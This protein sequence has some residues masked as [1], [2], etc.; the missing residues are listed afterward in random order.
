MFSTSP[1]Q[2]WALAHCRR[3][4]CCRFQCAAGGRAARRSN[5]PSQ[6][7]AANWKPWRR[8][9]CVPGG[10]SSAWSTEIP[11]VRVAANRSKFAAAPHACASANSVSSSYAP[12]KIMA[13]P[14]WIGPP[15]RN[16]YWSADGKAAYYS[17]ARIG[18]PIVDLHRVDVATGKDQVV[19]AEAMANAD[20]PGV[21]DR[22]G[23]HAAFIRN[24]D[25][26][27]RDLNSGRL[28]QITRTPQAKSRPYFSADGR[29]LRF[30]IE[31]DS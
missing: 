23:R 3:S 17:L 27:V 1:L 11:E 18:S 26:F 10:A 19:D 16:A 2:R 28:T 13:D 5:Q 9:A 6:P 22:A 8:S 20:G 31:K 14:E 7:F 4:S 24:H 29:L 25:I 12:E 15:V 21:Y 30:R